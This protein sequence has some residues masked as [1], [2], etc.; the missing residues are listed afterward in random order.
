MPSED[1]QTWL[2]QGGF[3]PGYHDKVIAQDMWIHIYIG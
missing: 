3:I 1:L 2:R